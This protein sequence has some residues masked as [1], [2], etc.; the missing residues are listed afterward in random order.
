MRGAPPGRQGKGRVSGMCGIVG[1]FGWQPPPA[2]AGLL[3]QRMVEAV[4]HRGPDARTTL[5]DGRFALGHA[6]LSILDLAGGAQPMR[7]ETGEVAIVFNGEVFNHV[8]LRAGLAAR[9]IRCRTASDTEVILRLYLEQGAR[10]VEAL[11]GD[12]A[13]AI[14]DARRKR[15]LLARDRVGVRPL[16]HASLPGGGLAFA[17]EA[18]ALLAVPG[19]TP[20]PDPMALG[21]IFALWAPLPPR[22]MFRDIAELPPGH[23]LEAGAD[24]V[25][26][27]R[28]WRPDFPHAGEEPD[29]PEDRAAEELAALL[30]DAVR[31]RLR[32][33]VP[34]GACLSGGLDS[35]IVARLAR[36]A[37]AGPFATFS[38]TFEQPEFDEGAAQRA[39]AAALGTRHHAIACG[40]RDIARLFPRML[41]HAERPVL[42]TA[43]AP[44]LMLAGLVREAGYK[45][46]LTGEG[47]DEV[48]AGYDIF[49]EAALRGFCARQ[50]ASRLRPLL[51]ERLYPWLP[52]LQVQAPAYREA[53]FGAGLDRL[54]DPLF[55]HL[56]RFAAAARARRFL[57]ADLQ[58]ALARHDP[59]EALRARLPPAF[60]RWHPL[61][62]AQYLEM[63]HLLPGYIL[64]A[65]GD[66]MAMAHGVEG[67]FPFLDPRLIDFAARLPPRLKLKGL[68]EKHILRRALRGRLPDSVAARPKQP[69]RAPDAACFCG[70]QAPAWVAEAL[71][72]EAVLRTGWFD[73][74]A[75]ALLA[76]KCAAQVARG[77]AVG[78]ADNQA[79][80]GILSAQ[81]WHREFAARPAAQLAATA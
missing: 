5:A 16:F 68:R 75:V 31:I 51:F 27:T 71:S 76:R 70:P 13:F 39:M 23:L 18:K 32:A 20:T 40:T 78:F 30:D 21:E 41:R 48:F 9:G 28:W 22:T 45:V 50:P 14:H 49:R 6:R 33:D 37:G 36:D 62:R 72:R 8:E 4:G 69:F 1:L 59:L 11:N 63:T 60:M 77:A 74:A 26:I 43:P 29:I 7:D 10:C 52:E 34:V 17:S 79:L 19:I 65:Q 61:H 24:G 25:R 53:F 58:A 12:F 54:D 81:L 38:V 64:S 46:V 55:S 80:V 44:M 3:L 42:R 67:R 73:P 56:P 35:A 57:D 66:R 2:A 47:A 15:L